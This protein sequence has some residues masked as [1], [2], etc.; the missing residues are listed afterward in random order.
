E[1]DGAVAEVVDCHGAER[2]GDALAGGEEHVE[3]A[4]IGRTGDLVGYR[5]ELVG[6]LAARR[7]DGDDTRAGVAPRDDASGGALDALGVS[8][9]GAAEL[10]DDQFVHAARIPADWEGT[11]APPA[12]RALPPQMRDATSPSRAR[13]RR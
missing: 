3:L 9:G 12:S 7:E 6:G 11:L 2:A 5:E 13:R 4:G 1:G 8:D 10:H